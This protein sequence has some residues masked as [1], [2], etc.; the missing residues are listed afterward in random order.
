LINCQDVERQA[1]IQA[2]AREAS[3]E[4]AQTLLEKAI[5]AGD[6]KL[7]AGASQVLRSV[8]EAGLPAVENVQDALSFPSYLKSMK[9]V[10]AKGI[11]LRVLGKQC[12]VE[13]CVT[14]FYESI[15][16]RITT[17]KIIEKSRSLIESLSAK[18]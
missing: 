14:C 6:K 2:F 5:K 4:A 11:P 8:L 10:L 17:E 1:I 16:Q 18:V 12:R 7:V 9:T 3:L 13:E 15:C